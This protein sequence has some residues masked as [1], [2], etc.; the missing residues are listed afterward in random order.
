MQSHA[1]NL[2]V[3]NALPA[4]Y[5]FNEFEIMEVV[6]SG[7]L[8]LFIVPGTINWSVLSRLKS[9]FHRHWSYVTK[10]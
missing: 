9:F 2:M 5:R 8:V 1:H 7:G 3:L 10:I 4:G 6:G